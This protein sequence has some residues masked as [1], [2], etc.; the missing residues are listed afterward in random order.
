[1]STGS[2]LE[3]DFRT[4]AGQLARL[5]GPSTGAAR[6]LGAL[7]ERGL[8][9][10]A[11]LPAARLAAE[12][13]ERAWQVAKNPVGQRWGHLVVISIDAGQIN[14]RTAWLVRCDCGVIKRMRADSVKHNRSR[15]CGCRMPARFQDAVAAGG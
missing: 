13:D 12:L 4:I 3:S 1:M 2:Y 15:S 14:N 10:A 5:Q 8:D 6:L 11:L 7:L 9:E